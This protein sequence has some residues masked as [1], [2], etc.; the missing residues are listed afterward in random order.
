M[1]IAKRWFEEQQRQG[2]HDLSDALSDVRYVA[3]VLHG[4]ENAEELSMGDICRLCRLLARAEERIAEAVR[5]E[6]VTA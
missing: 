1:S 2:A 6:E 3:R 5:A 4:V